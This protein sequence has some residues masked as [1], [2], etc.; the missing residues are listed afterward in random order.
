MSASRHSDSEPM[1]QTNELTKDCAAIRGLRQ[2]RQAP[3]AKRRGPPTSPVAYGRRP[4]LR[5][6]PAVLRP[7]NAFSLQALPRSQAM[8]ASKTA[9]SGAVLI[10][11]LVVLVVITLLGVTGMNTT[12]MQER[13]AGNM[14]QK[15]LALQAAEAALQGGLAYI[16]SQTVPPIANSTG[17][18]YVWPSCTVADL[19]A[20]GVDACGR[21]ETVLANWRGTLADVSEGASYSAVVS[22]IGGAGDLPSVVAQPRIYIEERYVPPLDVDQAS[23]GAGVHY[24]TVT[25]VGFGGSDSARAIVQSTVAKVYQF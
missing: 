10:L 3:S 6:W 16:E 1:P 12:V 17:A 14:R 22:G 23:Q 11:G 9:Q 20:G 18:N 21:L 7:A 25:A 24:Y 15:N 5:A 13:M 19:E 8:G 2:L 4:A